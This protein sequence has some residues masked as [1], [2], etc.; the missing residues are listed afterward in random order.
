MH[1]QFTAAPGATEEQTPALAPTLPAPANDAP[2][3]PRPP[4]SVDP[5][6][7]SIL[8][9]NRAY[10]SQHEIEFM[11]WLR[12]EIKARL[13]SEP[14]IAAGGNVIAHVPRPDKKKSGVLF[15]CHTDTCHSPNDPSRA[16]LMYDPNLGTIFLDE[17]TKTSCLGADD[18]AGVWI[19]LEM[20][21]EKVPGTYVFHRGEERG[22]VGA[23]TLA[24]VEKQWLEEFEIAVAFDRPR[25]NEVITHMGGVRVCSDKF[26]DALAARLTALGLPYE[27]S[28]R[29][30]L[31]DT[32]Q[33]RALICE[34]TNIGVG[35]MEQHLRTETLNYAHLVRLRDA[36]VQIDWD[37]LPVDREPTAKDEYDFGGGG[38]MYPHRGYH[39]YG[40]RDVNGDRWDDTGWRYRWPAGGSTS[41]PNDHP[42]HGG[43]KRKKKHRPEHPTTQRPG[44]QLA[45]WQQD[46]LGGPEPDILDEVQGISVDD[47]AAHLASLS[48]IETARFVIELAGEVAALRA[49]INVLK[50]AI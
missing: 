50:G 44:Q 13:G 49:K 40:G 9:H 32:R 19:M 28:K 4:E 25:C 36:V 23:S 10:E 29:G 39:G 41:T 48:S 34:C 43:K 26:A 11:A 46:L 38:I 3:P 5:T 47:L 22:C 18:G 14:R 24:R 16:Q 15:S 8:A 31:T 30:G 33:Y 1:E 6:L 45:G 7:V 42:N 37:S 20:I 21:R 2:P 17:K 12:A 35:Y 27:K